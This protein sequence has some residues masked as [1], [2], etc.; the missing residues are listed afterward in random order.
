MKISQA[1]TNFFE[2]NKADGLDDK[3][4]AW[5]RRRLTTLTPLYEREVNTITA[6]DLRPL[7]T[8]VREEDQLFTTHAYRPTENRKRSP[9]TLRSYTRGLKRFFNWLV[10]EGEIALS[11]MKGIRT[12]PIPKHNPKAINVEDLKRMREAAE[13]NPRDAALLA[14]LCSTGCRAEG[15]AKM[16]VR[17][18]DLDDGTASVIEKFDKERVVYFDDHAKRALARYLIASPKEKDDYL[19]SGRRHGV[20]LRPDSMW[21]L[22][23]Q[24]AKRANVSGR[25]NPHSIR[26]A[27]AREYL[28]NGGDL[29]SLS[30][31]MGHSSIVVTA[32]YYANLEDNHLKEKF[33]THA[34]LSARTAAQPVRS[35]IPLKE[36][37]TT[38]VS[39]EEAQ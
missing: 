1:A 16:K 4:N 24:I 30:Q 7:I 38:L 39:A 14:V 32:E 34:K 31:I 28:M 18:L 22:L 33:K 19:F 27:F 26:H 29:K 21:H 20:Y 8:K 37:T 11:P 12:P 23:K 17:D 13:A 3:T 2:A 9:V 6:L 25:C 15:A 36:L 35:S 5:Y 10:E